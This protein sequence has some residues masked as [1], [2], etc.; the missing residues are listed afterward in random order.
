MHSRFLSLYFHVIRLDFWFN[1]FSRPKSRWYQILLASQ[2]VYIYIYV[3]FLFDPLKV[4]VPHLTYESKNK[5]KRHSRE[6]ISRG[7]FRGRRSQLDSGPSPN[8]MVTSSPIRGETW[9]GKPRNHASTVLTLK[10]TITVV[11]PFFLILQIKG[12]KILNAI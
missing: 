12:Y 1:N 7:D 2:C 4:P 3:H 6:Q 11:R 10:K 5:I 9:G 8:L